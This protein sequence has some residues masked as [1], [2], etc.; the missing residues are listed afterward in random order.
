MIREAIARLVEKRGLTAQEAEE[1]M[2]EVMRGEATPAQMAAYLVA[3]RLKGE[4][5]QEITGSARA[6]RAHALKVEVHREVVDTCGTGG[7]ETG[8]FN[9]STTAALVAAAAGLYVAKHGNRS[10]SFRCGSADLMEALG[11]KI[12]LGP[13]EVARCIEKVGIG[14][15]FAPRFHPAMK[16]VAPVRKELGLRT[17]FNLLGP[18]TNPASAK[19]QLV[20]V[21]SPELTP[22]LA[23][24]LGG[25]GTRRALVV[26]GADGLDELSTTGPNRV[27]ELRDG[28]VTT[29]VLDPLEYGLPRAHLQDLGG[30]NIEENCRLT[31][32]VLKGEKGPRRDVVLLNTA[33]ILYAA[34]KA[35]DLVQ[36]LEAATEAID[37]GRARKKLEELVRFIRSL[38]DAPG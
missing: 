37:S 12:D 16:H 32:D 29:Y 21:Y 15:L 31:L 27:S 34:D 8:T 20:G 26:H 1:V 22:V 7:D 23:R 28:R 5:V 10:V 38:G 30:G 13:K 24:V 6:M 35:P 3:L 2:G 17:I 33:A 18:L 36:G 9:I 4:T 14:F 19:V 25:L 11:V